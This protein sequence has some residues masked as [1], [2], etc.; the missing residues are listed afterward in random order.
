MIAASCY[1]ADGGFVAAPF[2]SVDAVGAI[3][4]SDQVSSG[5]RFPLAGMRPAPTGRMVDEYDGDQTGRTYSIIGAGFEVNR[6]R[7]SNVGLC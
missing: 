1:I 4:T 6:S 2:E 3:N 7:T 5:L